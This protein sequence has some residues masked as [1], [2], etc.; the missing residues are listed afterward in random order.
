[1]E[2]GVVNMYGSVYKCHYLINAL[3][4]L[5]CIPHS[6]DG[7]HMTQ[8]MIIETIKNSSIRHWIFSGSAH[9]P[10]LE[11]ESK[12]IPL[13]IV[14]LK[15]KQCMLICYSMESLLIQLNI[16]LVKH[17]I[18]RKESF[19]LTIPT[20]YS[21]LPLVEGIKNPMLL[22]RNHKM[23]FRSNSI[24]EPLE[25]IASYNGECMIVSYKNTLC[26]QFHPEKSPDGKK[27]IVNWLRST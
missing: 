6:I 9:N 11:T 3:E 21:Q 19:Q 22:R 17:H 16:P 5:G 2:V 13:D 18:K 4:S 7:F 24:H 10:A 8:K 23:Y 25:H 27:L 26:L 20:V 15:G 14:K 1:M 12:Q